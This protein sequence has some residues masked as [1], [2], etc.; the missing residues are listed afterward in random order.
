MQLLALR[1]EGA[2]VIE[3]GDTVTVTTGSYKGDHGIV[4]RHVGSSTVFRF[5]IHGEWDYDR[6]WM[7]SPQMQE[8]DGLVRRRSSARTTK[9]G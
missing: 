8:H 5:Q 4:L 3:V 9:N 1:E 2:K 6:E 7:Y